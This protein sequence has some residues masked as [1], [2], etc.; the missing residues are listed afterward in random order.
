MDLFQIS[1][2]QQD[3]FGFVF[4]S[5]EGIRKSLNQGHQK[6]G[7]M[8]NASKFKIIIEATCFFMP[9]E[10]NSNNGNSGKSAQFEDLILFAFQG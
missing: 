8:K 3:Y 5:T 6:P 4:Y 1:I 7:S 10:L 9:F 2:V